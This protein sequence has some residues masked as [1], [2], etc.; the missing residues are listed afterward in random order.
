MPP[1]KTKHG[2]NIATAHFPK[3]QEDLKPVKDMGLDVVKS[4]GVLDG[5][6]RAAAPPPRRATT[7]L[8]PAGILTGVDVPHQ[9]LVRV[10]E[11]LERKIG[12]FD[13]LSDADALTSAAQFTHMIG[14]LK[15]VNSKANQTA[16]NIRK[17]KNVTRPQEKF[18]E[19]NEM[20]L[21][22]LQEAEELGICKE[23]EMR[24]W[25]TMQVREFSVGRTHI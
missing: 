2:T 1:K 10:K 21:R 22:L 3:P 5:R 24:N 17:S 23:G 4:M 16:N 18:D 8:A 12:T 14:V 20:L 7:Y 19:C 15:S 6:L 13:N 25:A 11:Q 9:R